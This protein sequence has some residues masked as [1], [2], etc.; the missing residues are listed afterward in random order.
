[1]Q[2]LLRYHFIRKI[3]KRLS[4]P[5]NAAAWS[6]RFSNLGARIPSLT[7]QIAY[8]NLINLKITMKKYFLIAII[9]MLLAACDNSNDASTDKKPVYV[10]PSIDYKGKF[11]KGYVRMPV[12][13]NKNAIKN[14]NRSRYYY[15]TKGKY[16]RKK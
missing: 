1:M 9:G 13:V 4:L 14:Q 7:K 12:S 10:K 2:M 11:R 5:Q 3:N 8:R 6:V 16:M 15:H